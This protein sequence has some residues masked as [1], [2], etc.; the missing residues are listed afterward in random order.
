MNSKL[1]KLKAKAFENNEVKESYYELNTEFELINTL[2][3]MRNSAGLTQ[4]QVAKR[5]GTKESNISRLEKGRGNPTI[6]T[7][8][9]YAKACSCDLNFCYKAV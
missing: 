1:Q 9:N 3:Q 8:M 4:V 6:K 5:M 7:L 2:L